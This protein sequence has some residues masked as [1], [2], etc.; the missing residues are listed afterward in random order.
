MSFLDIPLKIL[1]LMIRGSE[2]LAYI[3]YKL[4]PEALQIKIKQYGELFGI[5]S[6]FLMAILFSILLFVSSFYITKHNIGE[7]LENGGVWH[8][9]KKKCRILPKD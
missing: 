2:F 9:E 7:C 1:E 8:S 3:I 4:V 6:M 5:F